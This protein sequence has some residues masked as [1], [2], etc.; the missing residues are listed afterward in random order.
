MAQLVVSYILVMI[1]SMPATHYLSPDMSLPRRRLYTFCF[2]PLL[3]GCFFAL[4]FLLCRQSVSETF[5]FDHPRDDEPHFFYE[6]YLPGNKFADYPYIRSFP[7][8]DSLRHNNAI[9]YTTA[10]GLFG[11]SVMTRSRFLRKDI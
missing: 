7:N 4:N 8:E 5:M 1:A 2:A 6:L 3:L 10:K 11:I 9:E